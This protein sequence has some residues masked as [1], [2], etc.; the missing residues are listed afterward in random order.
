MRNN[1]KDT[2]GAAVRGIACGAITCI[3]VVAMVFASGDSTP[4]QGA[5]ASHETKTGAVAG[6]LLSP[7]TRLI[8]DYQRTALA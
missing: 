8:I 5:R 6:L 3:I 4:Q 2:T 7:R 1:T